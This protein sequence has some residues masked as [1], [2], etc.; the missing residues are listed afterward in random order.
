MKTDTENR[1]DTETGTDAILL[2]LK[3]D[4]IKLIK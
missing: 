1:G 2:Q 4:G 3:I